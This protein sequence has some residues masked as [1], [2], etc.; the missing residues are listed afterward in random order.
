MTDEDR[1]T[2]D[3]LDL[4]ALSGSSPSGYLSCAAGSTPS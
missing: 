1:I 3:G 2:V 4:P